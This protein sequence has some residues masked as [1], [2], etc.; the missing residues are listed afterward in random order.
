[1]SIPPSSFSSMFP[2]RVSHSLPRP[3]RTISLIGMP[4]DLPPGLPPKLRQFAQS[5]HQEPYMQRY[6]LRQI[7]KENRHLLK[8]E[9]WEDELLVDPEQPLDVPQAELD[10]TLSTFRKLDISTLI[11]TPTRPF[12]T[13][14][15]KDKDPNDVGPP[16]ATLAALGISE[17]RWRR[18]ERSSRFTE[19]RFLFRGFD[20]KSGGGY[21]GLNTK[22]GV[23]PHA[24]LGGKLPTTIYDIPNLKAEIRGHLDNSPGIWSHFSSWAAYYWTADLFAYRGQNAHIAILDTRLLESHVRVYHVP[25]LGA[26]HLYDMNTY[27]EEYLLYGPI[28]GPAYFCV[29]YKS[30]VAA[31][32]RSLW[33]TS[34]AL[35]TWERRVSVAKKVATLMRRPGDSDPDIVIA[36]T[37]VLTLSEVKVS[38]AEFRRLSKLFMAELESEMKALELPAPGYEVKAQNLGLINRHTY[39]E[40]SVP[41]KDYVRLAAEMEDTIISER[42]KLAKLERQHSALS[43][44]TGPLFRRQ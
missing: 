33:E 38:P 30:L 20:R 29:E 15:I 32:V 26:A 36:A 21:V 2:S 18:L 37:I 28:R 35:M 10:W 39:T 13:N 34:K 27:P 11:P 16:P 7:L 17:S 31:G 22:A 8:G 1:M 40:H 24:F 44:R 25:D 42:A 5:L 3:P 23:V 41:M 14:A 4:E 43:R 9:A 12:R 19:P 6:V